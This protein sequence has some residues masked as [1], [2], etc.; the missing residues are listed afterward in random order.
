MRS[1]ALLGV[2]L[3][4]LLTGCTARPEENFVA[5]DAKRVATAEP[6]AS[7]I[8]EPVED[9]ASPVDNVAPPVE[10]APEPDAA[11]EPEAA[12]VPVAAP[13]AEPRPPFR[14][15]PSRPRFVTAKGECSG[16]EAKDFPAISVDG[17]TI[18]VPRADQL[19]SQGTAGTLS[20]EWHDVASGS[21]RD[22]QPLVQNDGGDPFDERG[23]ARIARG[24]RQNA[25]AANAALAAVSWHTMEK[26][27]VAFYD[28]SYAA[29]THADHL[30]KIP[31]AERVVQIL[32]QHGE[33]V[34]RIPGVKVLERHPTSA[35]EPVA[36]Y[37][38][39]T[40][41]TVLIVLRT[42]LGTSHTCDPSYTAQVVR[43]SP[44]T[45]ATIDARPCNPAPRPAGSAGRIGWASCE[46]LKLEVSPTWWGI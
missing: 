45:F 26:L 40:T 9:V 37:A 14:P 34:L 25:K 13:R 3:G 31:P 28:Y 12:P 30:Q 20:L 4:H 6:P 43:W 7:P 27:P 23:C 39:R 15:S 8:A 17:K 32:A 21:I 35:E 36:V 5:D 16:V 19:Q 42:C 41:G 46:P 38:E 2:T 24:I 44:E 29:E 18:V 11:L 10:P 22:S 1:I 33:L